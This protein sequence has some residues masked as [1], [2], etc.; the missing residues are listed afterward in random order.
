[1]KR[2]TIRALWHALGLCASVMACVLSMPGTALG[3]GSVAAMPGQH[4]Q[5]WSFAEGAPADVWAL[6]QAPDGYLW[7]GTGSGLYRFDGQRFETVPLAG[8]QSLQSSN[9]T[10][11][12]IGQDGAAWMGFYA[13]GI[14]RL[15][16]DEVKRSGV[17]DGLPE[18]MVYRIVDDQRGSLWAA[19]DGGLA[20]HRG[21]RWQTMTASEG[22]PWKHADWL[23]LD[24]DG[25]L[26]ISTGDT[27]VYR[28][29]GDERFVR[30]GVRSGLN[31]VIAEAPDGA[32]WVSDRDG[33]RV[34]RPARNGVRH[35]AIPD[36]HAKRLLFHR[37]GALWGT[38]ARNG[39]AFRINLQSGDGVARVDRFG[40]AQGLTA[41]VAVPVL[42]DREGSV[43]IGTNLGLDRFRRTP[44]MTLPDLAQTA[45]AGYGL[46]VVGGQ[47]VIA[48]GGALYDVDA[49]GTKLR[50]RGLPTVLAAHADADD[51]LWLVGYEKLQRVRGNEV[52]D[53]PLPG[54]RL[55]R[56]IRAIASDEN[57]LWLSIMHQGL[58][59]YGKGQ[60]SVQ[61]LRGQRV[62]DVIATGGG[63]A[64]LGFPQ[65]RIEQRLGERIRT[66]AAADG[67]SVGN[68]S[69][70]HAGDGALFVAGE[71]GLAWF[72]GKRFHTLPQQRVAALNGITGIAVA[73]GNV[74]LN[75]NLGVV[76][77][78]L[79]ELTRSADPGYRLTEPLLL[80]ALD[81]VPGIA[82]QASPVPTL[83]RGPGNVLWLATNQGAA[84]FDPARLPINRHAPPVSVRSVVA[85]GR[86]FAPS[87]GLELPKR[88][89]SLQ[90]DYTATSLAMPE[91][92]RFRY[93]LEGLD[94]RWV[95]AGTRRQAFYTNPPPGDYTFQVIAA[96]QDGV[97][98]T[99]GAA[100][101][102]TIPPMFHQTPWFVALCI[103][104]VG[105]VLWVLYLLRL[106]ELGIHIRSRLHERHLERER[107]ARELHDTLLQSIQGLI[108]RFQ[109]V[110]ERLPDDAAPRQE[111]ER[112]LDR[113][114]AVLAEGRNRVLDLRASSTDGDDLSDAFTKVAADLAV[115]HP[116]AFRVVTEGAVQPLDPIVRDELFRIGREAL[117]NAYQHADA[118]TIDVEIVHARDELRL[119]FMDDGRGIDTTV[120]EGGRPGH[121]GLSGMRERAERIEAT[122]CIRSR[123]GS[124]TEVEVRMPAGSAYRPCLRK[125]RWTL[126][127]RLFQEES[128]P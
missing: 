85:D 94:Q 53:V 128:P 31:A 125:S 108:L 10:A 21:G 62:P 42:E 113:A 74:W 103:V 77:L 105:A 37:D 90:I 43:W 8:G 13:G 25:T 9:I 14:A 83:L 72:D 33:T 5:G 100:L 26:W 28:N 36:L 120:L 78:P 45:P 65:D 91:R 82:L 23:L 122:L 104:A 60:W 6:A 58:Y 64:W 40:P 93:R 73:G 124:G 52:I 95:E 38:D 88:T 18:G 1:M 101:P 35:A 44:I 106:K 84:W 121:W 7:L 34:I 115:D 12:T 66:F 19:I 102:I 89:A 24:R 111:M 22:Y 54:G 2:H 69:A 110:A 123:Q 80:D 48:S 61:P 16:R 117:V 55:G 112:A 47:A 11:L 59:R 4:H 107:I 50:L 126:I 3:A 119:R 109:A 98:N 63:T 17:E 70:I 118:E 32:I 30:T 39:G 29:R 67:L 92:V 99:Q 56:D 86:V 46:A 81:G 51:T 76:R 15:L 68:V 57:G 71:K 97:W 75:G 96:N 49:P 79:D 41:H 127:R 114:D 27:I 116:A 20:R 87:S